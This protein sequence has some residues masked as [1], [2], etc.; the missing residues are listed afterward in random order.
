MFKASYATAG[1]RDRPVDAALEAV[2]S[3]GFQYTELLGKEPHI[4]APP[5]GRALAEF[6]RIVESCGVEIES[7]H[8]P[9]T[10]E[11][12]GA[13]DPGWRRKAVEALAASIR[14]AGAIDA[15]NLVIHPVTKAERVP[16]GDDPAMPARVGDAV[17]RS[18]DEL[19][20]VAANA[21]VCMLLENLPYRDAFPFRTMADLRPL[22]DNY[23]GES[24]GLVV[25][26]GHAVILGD[27]PDHEIRIAG[28]RLRGTH[29][30]DVQRT[31][32]KDNHWVPGHGDIDW[33]AVR[34]AL[35]EVGYTGART[36]EVIYPR[37]G[38]SQDE[39]AIASFRVA[40]E[41]GLL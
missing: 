27:D 7:V 23:P 15:G 16:G 13:P 5:T 4:L 38:E 19:V 3:A 6:R 20:P 1:F 18:L 17:R 39:L 11:V 8:A 28:S 26:T 37:R 40:R 9:Y 25:D 10:D 30:Q 21:G 22:V 41:W 34:Q 36:F 35:D 24:V 29:L 31:G 14:F 32:Q 33:I 12:L 2:A